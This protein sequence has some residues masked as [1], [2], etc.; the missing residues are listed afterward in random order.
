M[1]RVDFYH[2]Q[3]SPLEAALPKLLEKVLAQSSRA[4]VQASTTE[5][6]EAL[7]DRLWQIEGEAWLPHGSVKDGFAADQPIWL[8]T[9]AERPNEADILFLTDGADRPDKTGFS[10]CLDLF[11]GTDPQA[12][13]AARTRWKIC[14][15]AGCEMHYWQQTERGGWQEKNLG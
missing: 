5:R 4:V 8:T 15:D 12:L 14:A 9:E 6:V 7:N 2:L 10:R 1:I 3:T 11:D 13:T